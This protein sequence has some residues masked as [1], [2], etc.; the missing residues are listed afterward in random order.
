MTFIILVRIA[1]YDDGQAA[2][3][4]LLRRVPSQDFER[5]IDELDVSRGISNEDRI[6]TM[7]HRASQVKQCLRHPVRREILTAFEFL[8]LR[9]HIQIQT[10]TSDVLP[11]GFRRSARLV[12]LVTIVVAQ[13]GNVL[14]RFPPGR[15]SACRF[16]PAL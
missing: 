15:I 3:L 4:R 14:F 2:I 12:P 10:V 13:Y 5:G 16:R 7:V 11:S 8:G 1:V 6:M 9:C